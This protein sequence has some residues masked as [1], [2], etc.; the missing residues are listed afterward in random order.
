MG[1]VVPNQ[2][3]LNIM[4]NAILFSGGSLWLCLFKNDFTPDENTTLANLTEATFDGY[5][6]ATG[7]T[8]PNTGQDGRA[9]TEK[10][11]QV[12]TK[13]VGQNNN[14]VYGWFV[15]WLD[16]QGAN[17]KLFACAR[18]DPPRPM[19]ATGNT[20]TLSVTLTLREDT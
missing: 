10:L 15:I 18:Q 19:D 4:S 1:V 7:F 6:R 8:V 12:F 5:A 13:A 17:P 2:A 3:E 11:N 16:G 9:R 20:I 14:T